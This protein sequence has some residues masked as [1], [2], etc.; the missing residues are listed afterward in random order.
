MKKY[1]FLFLL[2]F[3]LI[4][5][6]GISQASLGISQ[7]AYIIYNDTLPAFAYD[8]IN[9]YMV[10]KGDST[11]ND[12]YEII[13]SVLDSNSASTYHN[14]DT[15]TFLFPAFILPGDSINIT[16]DD[17]YIM[18]GPTT[19]YH[20]RINVI[21]IWPLAASAATEDSLVFNVYILLPGEMGVNEIDLMHLIK[22]Y[23]NPVINK[24]T[25]ENTGENSIEEVRIYD[26]QGRLVESLN[27]PEFICTEAWATGMYMINIQ[28]KGGKTHTI[29]V[30]KQ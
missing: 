25:L 2:S 10:N 16:L 7:T 29:R 6:K 4:S 11:F 9:I 22:A 8:S 3:L 26:S 1:V 27:Q 19:Q 20:Y 28:L 23:P 13:T 14:V 12:G 30:V 21:V 24:I 5:S 17:N 18:G 15:A